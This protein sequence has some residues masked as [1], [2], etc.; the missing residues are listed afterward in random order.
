MA[1]NDDRLISG[2][3]HVALTFRDVGE[4]T[5]Y[6]ERLFGAKI[7]RDYV[8]DGR[9]LVRQMRIGA[10]LLSMHQQGNGVGL[11][12]RSPTVGAGDICLHWDG[13][14]EMAVDRLK[15]REIA[16]VEGPVARNF[17]DGRP[18]QSVYFRDL[19]GNLIELMAPVAS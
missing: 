2:I 10:A 5:D 18:S 19:D 17:S 14:I 7:L 13:P 16:I 12:A 4:A 6:Y 9:L 11:V 8:V 3:D 1:Q 15:A